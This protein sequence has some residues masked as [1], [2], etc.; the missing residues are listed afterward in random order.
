VL[1]IYLADALDGGE[2]RH[3]LETLLTPRPDGQVPQ[4]PPLSAHGTAVLL[5]KMFG[6]TLVS[7]PM[8]H[9]PAL[10]HWGR[11]GAAQAMFSSIVS[12]WRTRAALTVF[13]LGWAAVMFVFMLVAAVAAAVLGQVAMSLAAVAFMLSLVALTTVFYVSCWF[14]FQDTFEIGTGARRAVPVVDDAGS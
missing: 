6:M 4:M 12:V 5:L 13:A 7:V 2:A 14:G 8:W 11:Q 1:L 9:A 10:V 3:W